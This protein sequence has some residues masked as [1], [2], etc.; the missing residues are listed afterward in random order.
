MSVTAPPTIDALP[1]P[2]STADAANFD[3]R[4]DGFLGALPAF[5]TQTDAVA[6]NVYANAQDAFDSA[7]V[8][9]VTAHFKGDWSSLTGA[10]A[11]PAAVRHA[12]QYWT[13]LSGLA[14]V[15]AATPG[16]SGSWAVVAA[17]NYLLMH[18]QCQLSKSGANLILLPKNGNT[19]RVNGVPCTVPDAGVTLAPP[20]TSGTTYLIYAIATAGVITSLEASTTAHATSTTAGNKGVE[21]K[22]GDD[23]R[24]LVGI[25]ATLSSAWSDTAASRLVRSYF[26]RPATDVRAAFT[27]VRS[28]ASTS[29][30]ELNTE[31]RNAFV[32]WADDTVSAQINGQMF[33]DTA[34]VSAMV[35]INWDGAVDANTYVGAASAAGNQWM[36]GIS[37]GHKTLAEGSHYTSINGLVSAAATASYGTALVGSYMSLQTQIG[38]KT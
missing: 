3:S 7:S 23:T 18:G 36:P 20:A 28:T 29:N 4:A 26:N 13:L 17:Q 38:G 34:G 31:V 21:I 2:P 1:T 16:V 15:T 8:A 35:G 25:A 11:V 22:S 27:A 33:A 9:T 12:G 24:T 5:A 37:S 6:A 32:C 30:V 19:L 10:L 14:D